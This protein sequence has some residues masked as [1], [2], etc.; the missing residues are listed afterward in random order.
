[1]TLAAFAV[2]A[3]ASTAA[4]TAVDAGGSS[5]VD[6]APAGETVLPP[7]VPPTYS[8]P[9]STMG[10]P[11]QSTGQSSTAGPAGGSPNGE[12]APG[13]AANG[14]P[15]RAVQAYQAAA[16]GSGC[17]L[18]W[19]LLAAIGRVESNH[20]RFAGA[21]LLADGRSDPPI[22]GIPLDG[23]PGVA[24]IGDT[25]GGRYDGDTTHDR[26]VGPMQFIPGTWALFATDGDHDGKTDPFDIDDA[27]AAAAKYL[28]RAGGDLSTVAGQRNAVYS[29]NRS[30]SYVSLVLALSA[31]YAGGAPVDE[32][33]APNG[34]P[35]PVPHSNPRQPPA[36]V[37]DPPAADEP[38]TPTPT[39]PKP[40]PKPTTPAPTTTAPTSPTSPTS[41][42]PT[43]TPA[44][45]T[46]TAPSPTPTC[47]P[48]PSPT[49]TPTGTATG[50]AASM[51]A[52]DTPTP[53]TSS[54]ASTSAAGTESA[55]AAATPTATPTPTLPPC[56]S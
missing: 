49:E 10:V 56:P 54:P 22:V 7:A 39:K 23:R 51:P 17:G 45:P 32:S 9:G 35:R 2:I 14:I 18:P 15:S 44:A 40:K 5:T 36:S 4:S 20:G 31:E 27:A 47:T 26:A 8:Y 48:V 21:T 50:N 24:A 11:T 12:A 30:D 38:N 3:A 28:C 37:G 33:P 29:Y 53:T 34:T 6:T 25:D 19:T 1:M 42:A 41:T 46:T 16:A 13:L 55:S 52:S 43:T